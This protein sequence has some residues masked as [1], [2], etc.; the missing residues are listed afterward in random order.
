MIHKV[1]YIG[2]SVARN[3]DFN[4]VEIDNNIRIR[5]V[6]AYSSVKDDEAK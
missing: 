1:L 3:A 6:K 2:D 4:K 5:T